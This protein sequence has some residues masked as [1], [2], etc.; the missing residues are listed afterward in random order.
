[1][2][3]CYHPKIKLK[4]NLQ[5]E[6]MEF[7]DTQAFFNSILGSTEKSLATKV[8]FKETD[9]HTL[10]FKSTYHPQ[11]T[12]R[13]LIKSQLIRFH[14][15]CTY[16]DDVEEATRTL[17]GALVHRVYSR[18][19]L[20]KIKAEVTHIFQNDNGYRREGQGLPL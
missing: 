4:H 14:R 15:I 8:Y 7:L 18:C 13:G 16:P 10:L 6:K 11:Y 5:K 12:Y 17:F 9:G 19:F 20:R 3:S 2:L 1:M